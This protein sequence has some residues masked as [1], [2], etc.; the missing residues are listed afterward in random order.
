MASKK[1]RAKKFDVRKKRAKILKEREK[2][3]P[4]VDREER[5]IKKKFKTEKEENL[6]IRLAKETKLYWIRAATGALSALIGTLIGLKSWWLFIWMLSLWFGFP[7]LVSF[8]IL[9]YKY[10]KE[11]WNWKNIIKPGIGI[12]FFLFMIFAILIHTLQVIT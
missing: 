7:F 5:E 3:Q 10:D 9:R 12:Y 8:I 4:K 1:K 6:E 2:Q 11:E